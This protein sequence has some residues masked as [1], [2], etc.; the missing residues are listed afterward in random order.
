[1]EISGKL[2]QANG[3]L[4][5]ARVGVRIEQSGGKLRLRATL[6]SKPGSRCTQAHQQRISI[7]VP[8]NLSG[9]KEAEKE[10]RKIGALLACDEFDWEAYAPSQSMP[11]TPLTIDKLLEQFGK[12]YLS[13]GKGKPETLQQEYL[14]PFK[15]CD[16][17][18]VLTPEL[19]KELILSKQPNTRSRLRICSAAKALSK[20]AGLDF[21]PSP[22]RGH[23][24]PTKVNPRDIPS[25]TCIAQCRKSIKNPAWRWVYGMMATYGLRNHEVFRLD[26]ANF[27]IIHVLENTKTGAR[28][29]WPCYPEWA[30]VWQLQNYLLPQIN[31]NRSNKQIGTSVNL[32]L[33]SRISFKPY[34]LR[35]AWAIRTSL[36]GWP[37][38]LAARQMGHSC[39]M[40]TRTYHRWL[41]TQHQ[42]QIYDLLINRPDRPKPPLD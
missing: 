24:S 25:D 17:K 16:P 7:G 30:E 18:A 12:H 3:R 13:A 8:A 33:R 32:Y 29:V 37:V 1:M 42:Q 31:L 14:D 19:L 15:G 40:H 36:F 22:W 41:N 5:A 6:P 39:E 10:A 21:D 34:D 28:E 9:L 23:Y 26:L 20:F 2:A 27:P 38:E 35:H 11:S 4:K